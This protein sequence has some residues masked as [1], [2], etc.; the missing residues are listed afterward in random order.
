MR[1]LPPFVATV[2][3]FVNWPTEVVAALAGALRL[4]GVQL[5]GDELPGEAA[6]LS[7]R[8][9]VIKAFAAGPHFQLRTLGKYKAASAF[10]LDGYRSGLRG[11]TGQTADWRLAR[12]AKR[13]GRVI[14]AG[15]LTPENVARAISE[16]QPFGDGRGQRRGVAPGEK[17]S[18]R[19]AR[20]DARSRGRQPRRGWGACVRGKK[21]KIM[22]TT[23]VKIW[24]DARGRFGPYGGRYVPETLVAPLEELERAYAEARADPLSRANWMIAAEFRRASHAAAIRRRGSPN[25]SAARAFTSSAKTCCTP[26]RTRSTTASAKALLARAHGQAPHHRGNRRGAARRGHGHGGRA[27]WPGMRGLHGHGRHGA[28]A[29]QRFAHAPAGRGSGGREFRQPHAKGRDQRSHARLGD[30]CAHHALSARLGAGRAS[31][32]HD[33]ARFS[34]RDRR[35]GARA[36]SGSRRPPAGSAGRLRGRRLQCDRAV[37]THFWET[38]A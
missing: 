29:A 15:G 35:R 33:G 6:E 11:G 23:A 22:S 37:S 4:D 2:G 17:G 19:D 9:G 21:D 38:P 18:P 24:P 25:I 34:S 27:P 7:E 36:D 8:F 26:A 32:S 14:L 20:A 30:Q 1:R 28:A 5:H 10:L 31:L 12:E 3:V 16:V 13:Y